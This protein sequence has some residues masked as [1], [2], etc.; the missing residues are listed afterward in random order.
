MNAPKVNSE[1]V[2]RDV[3]KD[4]TQGSIEKGGQDTADRF[5]NTQHTKQNQNKHNYADH[6]GLYRNYK[7]CDIIYIYKVSILINIEFHTLKF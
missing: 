4:K 6:Q 7:Y 5:I 3:C 2:G 1:L